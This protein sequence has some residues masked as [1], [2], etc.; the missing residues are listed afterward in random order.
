MKI[1]PLQRPRPLL[2]R[3]VFS[4]ASGWFALAFLLAAANTGRAGS[5]YQTAQEGQTIFEQ[6]C[7]ACHKIGGGRLVGPDLQGVTSQRDLAWIKGFIAAPDKVLASGDPIAAQLLAESNNVPMPNLGLTSAEVDAVVAYLES[8]GAAPAQP[9]AQAP[10]APL[11]GD[12]LR[13]EQLFRGT[14]ALANGAPSCIACHTAA[15]I[16][17]FGGGTLGP[18]LTQVFTRYGGS[19][20][21]GGVLTTLPFPTMQSSF[22]N[23]LLTPAEQADLLAYFEKS[24]QAPA[25]AN[26]AGMTNLF[27]GIGAAGALALFGMMAFF[28]PRQRQSLSDALR[29]RA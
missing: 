20:G 25:A 24:A 12:P 19:A 7:A 17:A 11:V 4:L 2:K 8:A 9:A 14:V 22:A 6:R 21:L 5:P 3:L 18:D 29:K 26:A 27:L 10:A 28:W 23:R 13:G 16:G 15:G 1:C